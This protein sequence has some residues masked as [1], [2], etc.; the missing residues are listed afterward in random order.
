MF[1]PATESYHVA[2]TEAAW[3]R[4]AARARRSKVTTS[5]TEHVYIRERPL[6]RCQKRFKSINTSAELNPLKLFKKR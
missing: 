4:A 6:G 2:A 5:N 3:A 1:T